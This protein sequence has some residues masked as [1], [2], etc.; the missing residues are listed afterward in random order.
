MFDDD[1]YYI[2]LLEQINKESGIKFMSGVPCVDLIGLYNNMDP[3]NLL[4]IP[5]TSLNS[6]LNMVNG[7]T[8]MGGNG[9]LIGPSN[10]IEKLDLSFNIRHNIKL[11]VITNSKI[12]LNN[13]YT[14]TLSYKGKKADLKKFINKADK[15]I[16][17]IVV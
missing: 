17:I 3:K 11:Y 4:Y 13:K 1:S 5:A 6:A 12:R 10:D 8:L 16:R 7:A 15:L 14:R 9:I 2:N